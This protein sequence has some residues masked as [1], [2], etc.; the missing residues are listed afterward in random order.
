MVTTALDWQ[1]AAALGVA[2]ALAAAAAART[3][4]RSAAAFLRESAVIA[5]LYALWQYIGA[6]AVKD[7]AGAFGR[8]RDVVSLE[9]SWHLPDEA[10]V[11]RPWLGHPLPLQVANLYYDTLHFTGMLVFLL[12]LFVRHRDR[13]STVRNVLAVSTALCLAVQFLPVAPPRLLPGFVDTATHYGQSV[14][15]AGLGADQ[16][17]AMPSVHVAWALVIGGGVVY[18][19]R[20]SWRWV[21]LGYPLLT[22]Y[23]VVVT[24]NH[25]WLD[26]LVASALV[27]LVA[28]AAVATA[29]ARRVAARPARASA[30][31]AVGAPVRDPVAAGRQ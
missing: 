29:R 19:S 10:A 5:A 11:Q 6:H 4:A 13:Y 8:A 15:A 3:R 2:L 24:G 9:R 7:T 26:G 27:A 30:T 12:W 25:F 21:A 1:Q 16:L 20:R 31:P 17:S 14:Y 28:L 23:V 18:A 22:G